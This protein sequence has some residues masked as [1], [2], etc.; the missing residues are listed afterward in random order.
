MFYDQGIVLLHIE[1]K[2]TNQPCVSQLA[3]IVRQ[4]FIPSVLW[5]GENTLDILFPIIIIPMIMNLTNFCSERL[6]KK[7]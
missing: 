7:N 1:K 2:H 6:G 5:Y 3:L 4:T